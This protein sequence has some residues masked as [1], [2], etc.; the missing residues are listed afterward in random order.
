MAGGEGGG[1]G[2]GAQDI[3]SAPSLANAMPAHILRKLERRKSSRLP[4]R[5]NEEEASQPSTPVKGARGDKENG[6]GTPQRRKSMGAPV[7]M[8]TP[9]GIGTPSSRCVVEVERMRAR[10][11]EK[12]EQNGRARAGLANCDET[13]EFRQMIDGWRD[14]NGVGD[15]SPAA[16]S[17]S[18]S[19]DAAPRL[20]VCVRKRP[21]LPTEQADGDFDVL[22]LMTGAGRAVLHETRR[23]VDMTR[24]LENHSFQ[25]DDCFSEVDA[26][27]AI[28]SSACRP[29]VHA[30]FD[31]RHATAFAYGQTGSGKVRSSASVMSPALSSCFVR[32][33]NRSSFF[34]IKLC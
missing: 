21:L 26:N 27:K 15:P 1:G 34:I 18:A 29:L 13:H 7:P 2:G 28:Y 4:K 3:S 23:R 30:A 31:G 25:L 5:D 12:R 33:S 6:F 8:G 11:E 32:P 9:G 22:S 24:M 17:R 14:E 16:V 10:R 19:G 20:H